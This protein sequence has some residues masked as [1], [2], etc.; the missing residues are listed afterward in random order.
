VQR[1]RTPDALDFLL[2]QEGAVRLRCGEQIA[3]DFA[4]GG[5]FSVKPT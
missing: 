5:S 4:H 2:G 1:H 3:D